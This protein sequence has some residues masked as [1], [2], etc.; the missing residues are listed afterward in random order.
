MPDSA[1][2]AAT[3]SGKTCTCTLLGTVYSLSEI[4]DMKLNQIIAL[5]LLSFVTAAGYAQEVEC[6]Q[7]GVAS[8]YADKFVGRR[9]AS[10]ERYSQ[11]QMTCAHRTLPFG[12]KLKVTNTTNGKSIIVTVNDRGPYTKGRVLD[13]S[14]CAASELDFIHAGKTLVLLETIEEEAPV[15]TLPTIVVG[16]TIHPIYDVTAPDTAVN[17]SGYTIKIGS[18]E[19]MYEAHNSVAYAQTEFD[20]KVMMQMVSGESDTSYLVFVGIFYRRDEAHNF[21]DKLESYY[22]EAEMTELSQAN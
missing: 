20:R 8:F 5:L 12:T 4:E 18:Y 13:L 21:L 17:E 22:P 6:Q 2:L 1:A 16:P 19:T 11:K 10:G 14:K 3:L 9:T 7:T 15:E